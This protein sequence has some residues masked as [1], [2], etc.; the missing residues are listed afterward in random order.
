MLVI[1]FKKKIIEIEYTEVLQ[2][3]LFNL[4]FYLRCN[5]LIVRLLGCR[6]TINN[7]VNIR[8]FSRK[9][10]FVN[11]YWQYCIGNIHIYIYI[12]IL[13][14]ENLEILTVYIHIRIHIDRL[15]TPLWDYQVWSKSLIECYF[16]YNSIFISF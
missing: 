13:L 12:L 15:T 8:R 1:S 7:I 2:L 11:K 14:V 16:N 6:Q 5:V 10:R 4:L 9:M 3:T